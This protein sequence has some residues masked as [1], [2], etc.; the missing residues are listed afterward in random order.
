MFCICI[1]T[2]KRAELLKRLILDVSKQIV[3]PQLL[4]VVDGDPESGYVKHVL[5]SF[6]GFPFKIFI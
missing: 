4:V 3:Q 6:E 2:Y 1:C 5:C